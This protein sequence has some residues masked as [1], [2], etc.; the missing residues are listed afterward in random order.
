VIG[1]IVTRPDPTDERDLYAIT[2]RLKP[3]GKAS[4]EVVYDCLQVLA[5][6][7]D[8]PAAVGR[9]PAT[10]RALKAALLSFTENE[11]VRRLEGLKAL[12]EF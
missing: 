5:D 6:V 3:S 7:E 4:L 11:T 10:M 12:G 9:E 2:F 1:E 8:G